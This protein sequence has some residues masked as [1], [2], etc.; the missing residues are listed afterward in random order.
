MSNVRHDTSPA[1]LARAFVRRPGMFIGEPVTFDRA[2]A[3][4]RGFDDALMLRDRITTVEGIAA[5][6]T[7]VHAALLEPVSGDEDADLMRLEPLAVALFAEANR[8]RS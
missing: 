8:E 7:A 1:E 2:A 3:W 5:R 4:L 6:P